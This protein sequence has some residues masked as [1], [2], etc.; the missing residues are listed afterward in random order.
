MPYFY[1]DQYYILLV[2]PAFI[3]AVIAQIRVSSTYKRYSEIGSQS[4]ITGAQV[5]RQILD[6]NGLESVV[7]GQVS[8]N[9]TDNYNPSTNTV[10]LSGG[11]YNSS[12]VAALGIAAHE[13]GH[14]CQHNDE[15]GPLALRNFIVPVTQIGSTLSPYLIIAGVLFSFNFLIAVG[16]LFFGLAVVFQLITLPVEFNASRR[17]LASLDSMGS[18][19][20]DELQMTKKVLKAAA[21][22]Y[23]AAL[24]VS[25]ASFLRLMLLFGR[26]RD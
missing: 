4:G 23:V 9:L 2:I 8:G 13:V 12:S 15:Y 10:N 26:R 1:I 6:A 18:L 7:V 20:D 25:L 14:A 5:A 22:T 3:V 11:V 19:T 17:A 16:I 21:M 24:A